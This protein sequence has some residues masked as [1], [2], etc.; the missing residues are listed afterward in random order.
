M[1]DSALAAC[2]GVDCALD[3]VLSS[4]SQDLSSTLC[5]YHFHTYGCQN[6]EGMSHMPQYDI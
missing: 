6:D 1:Y 2:Y 4:R 5:Q 3:E